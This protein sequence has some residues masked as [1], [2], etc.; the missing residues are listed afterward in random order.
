MQ[1]NFNIFKNSLSW[2]SFIHQLNSD[3]LQRLILLN[4]GHTGFNLSFDYCEDE[5]Q[6][7]IFN[8]QNEMI[9]QFALI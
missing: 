2:V 1:V 4:H 3:I 6:G 9:G 7:H 5:C 8:E